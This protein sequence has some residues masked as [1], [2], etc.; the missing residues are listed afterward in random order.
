M[1]LNDLEGHISYSNFLESNIEMNM[2]SVYMGQVADKLM[3]QGQ[4]VWGVT[5]LDKEIFLL[6]RK[7]R[8]QVE[9][10]DVFTYRLQRCLTVPN[11]RWFTNMTSCKHYHCLYIGDPDVWCV[12]RLHV[13]GTATRWSVV[14]D[15]AE[16]LS[17]NAAHNVIVTCRKR[18]DQRPKIKEFSSHGNLLRE[19]ILPDDVIH[20]LHTIQPRSGQFIV[21]HGYPFDPI[22]GVCIIRYDMTPGRSRLINSLLTFLGLTSAHG[23]SFFGVWSAFNTLKAPDQ[24]WPQC[25]HVVHS[26]DGQS[27]SGIG[28][29]DVPGHLAVDG[30]D[31]VLPTSK[32]G[33]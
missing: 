4:P 21:C 13:H 19:L 31:H 10:Y 6:R 33:E 15:H 5:S 17:V 24:H 9:V 29:Y 20:P 23:P 8:D 28:Q 22:Q 2:L 25:C 1:T 11:A 3:S 7:E 27:D 12:H 26:H 18:Q 30:K 32:T 14:N 16:G